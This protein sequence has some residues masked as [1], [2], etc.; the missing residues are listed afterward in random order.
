[1]IR[2]IGISRGYRGPDGYVPVLN[3]V[4]LTFD[5]RE[6]IGILGAGS[7]G[8]STLM[9]ILAGLERPDDGL[10]D[11][12]A[13][14]SWPLGSSHGF[15]PDLTGE[16][17]VA[18]LARIAGLDP[19]EAVIFCDG[20][21]ELGAYFK[22]AMSRYSPGM[23]AQLAFAFSMVGRPDMYLADEILS[24]GDSHFREKCEAL[25]MTR[26]EEAGL[27][28]VSK[29]ARTLKRYCN[30]L[31]AFVEGHLL[32]CDTPEQAEDLIRL[33]QKNRMVH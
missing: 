3:D 18:L 5:S 22:R 28:L 10:L 15:H 33:A 4:S 27:F 12:R 19:H 30:R 31:F 25:L 17:N 6:R 24:A 1:M 11:C 14:L 2:M 9:R 21:A 7:S 8:K 13:H 29:H 32:P 23:R 16:E 20:F 26:L